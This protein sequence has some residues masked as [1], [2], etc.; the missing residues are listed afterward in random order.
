M[1]KTREE[2]L[3][4]LASFIQG[5]NA[6]LAANGCKD[7][8][9]NEPETLKIRNGRTNGDWIILD[10]KG[11]VYCFVRATNGRTRTLGELNA[12]DLHKPA[13]YKAPAKHARGNLFEQDYGLHCAGPY[14]LQYL[15]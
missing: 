9:T 2:I 15:K 14:G 7:F 4:A 11:S 8:T 3:A 5:V 12:G 6:K 1:E 10:R 13:S